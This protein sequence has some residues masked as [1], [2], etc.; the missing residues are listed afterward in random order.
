MTVRPD[1][2]DWEHDPDQPPGANVRAM[3]RAAADHPEMT[4]TDAKTFAYR[5]IPAAGP[6]LVERNLARM[7]DIDLTAQPL[8]EF[9]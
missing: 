4:S 5:H 3:L 9:M 7:D 6:R 8:H 2:L 1:E